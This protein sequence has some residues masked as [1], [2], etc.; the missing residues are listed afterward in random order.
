MELGKQGDSLEREGNLRDI[1][2]E[3]QPKSSLR[4]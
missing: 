3:Q 2:R 4:G 1:V